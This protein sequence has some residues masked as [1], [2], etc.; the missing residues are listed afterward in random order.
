MQHPQSQKSFQIE[1]VRHMMQQPQIW[2]MNVHSY[3][4]VSSTS[5]FQSE[6]AFSGSAMFN[7]T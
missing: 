6:L 1:T 3:S 2:S 4:I 7:H 5:L